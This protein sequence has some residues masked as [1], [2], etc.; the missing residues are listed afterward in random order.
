MTWSIVA[1]DPRTGE[2]GI[3]V[4]TRFFA[5][6]AIVPHV[7]PGVGAIAT[8]ALVNPFY[9]IDGMKLLR[10]GLSA[11]E[12]LARLLELDAGRDHRQVHLQDRQGRIAAHTGANCV[13]WA[14]HVVGEGFSVAGNMLAGEAVVKRTAEAFEKSRGKS[15]AE[16]FLVALEA[17]EAAGGDKRG[18]QSAAIRVHTTEPWPA[19][20]IRV[21][22]HVDPLKEL[23]RL[24]DASFE[25]WQ[26]FR[27][28]MATRADYVGTTDR[29]TINAAIEAAQAKR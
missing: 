14:G 9:G 28:F 17:G 1:H 26:V 12:T 11:Q 25:R 3:G 10:A 7:E 15:L 20:D 27:Q 24:H 6:G 4:A 21:D 5:V 23:R 2:I 13:D 22:D 18:K 19:L 8:Q 29:D 16:R